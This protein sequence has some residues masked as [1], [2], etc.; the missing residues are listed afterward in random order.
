MNAIRYMIRRA[1]P[2]QLP[3]VVAC[4]EAA[5][6]RH[7]SAYTQG[8]FEDTVPN[9]EAMTRRLEQMTIFCASDKSGHVVGTVACG[10]T[11]PGEGHLRGMAV[12]PE[13]QGLGVA[14]GL[15][16]AVEKELRAHACARMTLDTTRPLARAIRFYTRH[17]FVHTGIVTDFHGMP[18]FEYEKK[19]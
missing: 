12:L 10:V 17:G 3:G 4:L 13:F 16:N 8:A 18:L 5:F 6:E 14:E 1:G 2:E 11:S 15:L 7:R 9:L 19:L